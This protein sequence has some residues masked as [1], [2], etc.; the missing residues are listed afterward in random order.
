MCRLKKSQVVKMR[1]W[2]KMQK[3]SDVEKEKKTVFMIVKRVT[4][5]S[6]RHNV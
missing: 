6:Y 1:N 5:L 2:K 4:R 3:K